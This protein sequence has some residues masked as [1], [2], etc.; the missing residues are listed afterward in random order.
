MRLL[1]VDW[2]FFFPNNETG[3]HEDLGPWPLYDWS[4]KESPFYETIIWD[5]RAF[6]F[7][8]NNM[9]LP[10][11]SGY[12][13]FWSRFKFSKHA[14]LFYA[15]S[16][17]FAAIPRVQKSIKHV[18]LLDAHHD[19]GYARDIW[20]ALAEGSFSCEDWMYV[21]YDAV[22]E[23]FYPAWK[24]EGL[25]V[26][27]QPMFDTA[28]SIDDGRDF[29]EPYDRVFVC[30]SPAWVPPWCDDQFDEFLKL[31]PLSRKICLQ[32]LVKRNFSLEENLK[33]FKLDQQAQELLQ[34]HMEEM[35][36]RLGEG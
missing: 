24:H 31:A 8:Y 3:Y 6:G 35:N 19:S 18:T 27:K 26:E 5:T 21:Y 22:R 23:M 1:V 7:H 29:P 36:V 32:D 15:D 13:N 14:Q 9:V 30:R 17:A 25:V 2:D 10:R 28:R 20:E 11:C 12:E 34:K 4:H 16:N 33:H